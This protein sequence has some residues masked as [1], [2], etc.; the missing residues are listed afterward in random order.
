MSVSS[1]MILH[2]AVMAV[3][4]FICGLQLNKR[5]LLKW[6]TTG[7][8]A[9]T[10]STLY[11]VAAPLASLYSTDTYR[12][13]MYYL[14][15]SG[16]SRALWIMI[17]CATGTIA[18]FLSYLRTKYRPVTWKIK[19]QRYDFSSISYLILFVFIVI[20]FYGL[21]VFRAG[22]GQHTGSVVI[23]NGRFVGSVTG[24]HHVAYMFLFLPMLIF[25]TH[26]S[27]IKKLIG[28]AIAILLLVLSLPHSHSRFITVSLFIML[29]IMQTLKKGKRWPSVIMIV[30]IV[31][32]ASF[33]QIRGH[34]KQKMTD[35]VPQAQ[36][37]LPQILEKN[38]SMLSG[39][40]TAMLRV[41]WVSSHVEDHYTGYNFGLPTLNY[42]ITGWL[43]SRFFPWKYF[44]LDWIKE[45]RGSYPLYF[46]IFLYGAKSALIGDFYS[47][48]N[49]FG[50]IIGMWL[51]GFIGRRIDGMIDPTSPILL[52][53]I[54]I[55][56]TGTLWMV[57]GSDLTWGV[58]T[59]GALTIPGV[60]L[61][62][63]MPKSGTSLK[64]KVELRHKTDSRKT[65]IFTDNTRYTK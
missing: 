46:D 53:S 13:N 26:D 39:V 62:L 43:P 14:S 30:F 64:R 37:I 63:A 8:W 6:S 24:Y 25:L 33:L 15:T 18:F 20:G 58:N 55:C 3:I 38:I 40:D 49:L 42:V 9:L 60:A 48:G 61:W 5:N 31:L 2:A 51:F 22:L 41:W 35:I 4:L 47:S 50:V 59:L 32:I 12:W 52:K 16:D 34:S 45:A 7:F 17:V 11:F 29:S 65:F 10:S 36:E 1:A 56:W 57:W 27:S 44:I 21:V 23:E 19:T 54:G 28:W